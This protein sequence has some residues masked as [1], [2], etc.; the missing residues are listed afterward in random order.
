MT[1]SPSENSWVG[2]ETDHLTDYDD[3]WRLDDDEDDFED[4]DA[5]AERD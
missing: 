1:A 2:D 4:E 3:S 5:F